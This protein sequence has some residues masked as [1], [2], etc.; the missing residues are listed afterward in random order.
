MYAANAFC[1]AQVMLEKVK[2]VKTNSKWAKSDTIE[3]CWCWS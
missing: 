1:A 3:Y 2:E